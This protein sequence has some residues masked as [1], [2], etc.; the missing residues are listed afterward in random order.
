LRAEVMI[1]AVLTDGSTERTAPRGLRWKL[2]AGRTG[3]RC[4]AIPM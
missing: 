1:G 3:R 2:D 4:R